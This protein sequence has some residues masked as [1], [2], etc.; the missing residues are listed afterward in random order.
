MWVRTRA[1]I[2]ISRNGCEVIYAVKR[3]NQFHGT[4]KQFFAAMDELFR[5][6]RSCC[7]HELKFILST[8]PVFCSLFKVVSQIRSIYP[9]AVPGWFVFIVMDHR[10]IF[11]SV[12]FY[13]IRENLQIVKYIMCSL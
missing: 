8:S 12:S 1:V 4:M 10:K 5:V 2:T 6:Q 7:E 13:F 11:G 3:T 9:Y